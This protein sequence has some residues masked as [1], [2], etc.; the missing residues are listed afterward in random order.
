MSELEPGDRE[1]CLNFYRTDEGTV[2]PSAEAANA[3]IERHHHADPPDYDASGVAA[4]YLHLI[5][6]PAAIK[7]LRSLRRAHQAAMRATKEVTDGE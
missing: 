2:W 1:A 6:H 3:V 7:A 5:A 4:A